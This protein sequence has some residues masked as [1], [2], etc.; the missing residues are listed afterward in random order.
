MTTE[1]TAKEI[2]AQWRIRGGP[3]VETENGIQ[4]I[5]HIISD[6]PLPA[7]ADFDVI[8]NLQAMARLWLLRDEIVKVLGRKKY[9]PAK[10]QV[11]LLD[12]ITKLEG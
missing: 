6:E 11:A 5:P 4:N 7:N 12:K 9:R 3:A 1:E 2:L 10:S 8:V